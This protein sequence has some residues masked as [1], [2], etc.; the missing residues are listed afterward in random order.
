MKTLYLIR[1]AKSDWSI[2]H[3]TD[4][5]RPLNERGYNDAHKMS[6]IVKEKTIVPDLIISSPAVRAIST[7]LIFCRNLNYDPKKIVINKNLYDTE[8]KDYLNCISKIDDKHALVFLFGHNPTIT[9]TAN[10]LTTAV[11]EEMSTC[12]IAGIKSEQKTWAE[13]NKQNSELFYF[14]YPKN[15][16]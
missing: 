15:H 2:E 14:D 4:I 13:F 1:H 9:N 5:D 10:V 8:V 12:C 16:S 11:T 3:L 7:A 6:S